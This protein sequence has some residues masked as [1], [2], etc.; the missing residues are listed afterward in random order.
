[1]L[2]TILRLQFAVNLLAIYT[3]V[4]D[5]HQFLITGEGLARACL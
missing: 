2:Q 5:L 4:E 1:M 3:D